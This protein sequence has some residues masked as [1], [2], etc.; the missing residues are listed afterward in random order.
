MRWKKNRAAATAASAAAYD[1]KKKSV[2]EKER[3]KLFG[4]LDSCPFAHNFLLAR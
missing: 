3:T 1:A 2:G 4:L